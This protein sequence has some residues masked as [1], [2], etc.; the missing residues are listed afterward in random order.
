MQ[1]NDTLVLFADA[2]EDNLR[3]ANAATCQVL[4]FYLHLVRRDEGHAAP[5]DNLRAE[6]IGGYRGYA[7]PGTFALESSDGTRIGDEESRLFPH[8]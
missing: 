6:E 2:H 4:A 7:A 5:Q 1:P 8:Q 3:R